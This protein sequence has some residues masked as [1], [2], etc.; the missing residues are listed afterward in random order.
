MSWKLPKRRSK[1]TKNLDWGKLLTL[2]SPQELN[3]VPYK[4]ISKALKVVTNQEVINL[5]KESKVVTAVNLKKVKAEAAKLIPEE[6]VN[7]EL[8]LREKGN[9]VKISEVNLQ[10]LVEDHK[11]A[12]SKFR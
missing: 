7:L 4:E 9:K 3:K 6:S 5:S 11:V 2:Q 10:E 8:D 1:H 12:L